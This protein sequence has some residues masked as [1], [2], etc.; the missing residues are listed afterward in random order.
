M[1]VDEFL[2]RSYDYVII[3]GGTAGLVLAARLSEDP[4]VTVGVLEAGGNRLGDPLVDAPNLFLQ[5]WDKP[6]YDWCY[7]TVPQKGTGGRV[8]GWARGKALGGSSA[9][10]YNMFSMA[11][12]QDLDNWAELGNP[13]WGFDDLA[14]YYRKFETYNTPSKT[15]STKIN[16]SYIDPL[17]RGPDGP[18]QISF[19]ETDF[20]WFQEVWPPTCINAGL[21]IPKDPRTGSALGG[22][23]QLNTV[24][25]KT[26]KRSYSANA[27][28]E[29]NSSRINLS[30]LT[31]ALVAK[32]EF[33]KGG[34]SEATATGVQFL[35]DGTS[36]TVKAS[37]EVVV[38]GGVVNSPQILE[39]SGIGSSKLLDKVGIDVVVDNEGVGENLNDHAACGI[40]LQVKDEYPTAEVILRNPEIAQQAME[41]YLNH[42]A[43]PFTNAPTTVGFFSLE[44]VD[45]NLADPEKHVRSL[46]SDH[47][48]QRPDSDPAGRDAVLAKS[49][50]SPKEA[51]GQCVFL[52]VGMDKNHGDTPSKLFVHDAPGNWISLGICSTRSFSR[53]SIH[54]ESSDPTKHPIIDPAYYA[55]P[56][57]LD[58]AGR[59]VMYALKLAH[60]EPLASTLKK[61]DEG[62]LILHPSWKGGWPKTLDKAKEFAA[63]NTVTEYHPVGTCAMLPREKGGVVNNECKVYGTSNVRVVDASIFPTHVQGNIVSL[64]YAVSEKAADIIKGT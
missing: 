58:I 61:D 16:D 56:L 44:M 11:S 35:V 45:P 30:V 51:I 62:N 57:D 4:N 33:E 19:C 20:Q 49:V 31:N 55:H 34:G 29:P 13:G 12:R 53:G 26:M 63:E 59:S 21:P 18:V 28:Y 25:P 9:I 2:K 1:S 46:I 42:K 36:H 8:H 38:C 22:F 6:E 64:V 48:K 14:P 5:L 10:N 54:I 37:K 17:L 15:L 41:A 50:L 23:N 52:G 40:S 60:V 24:D 39:L 27:Y 3:G 7:K 43:G 47:H 32:I